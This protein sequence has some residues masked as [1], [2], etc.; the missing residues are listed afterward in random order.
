MN[1]LLYLLTSLLYILSFP[2]FNLS[3][4]AWV[5]L[6]PL[7]IAV[8]REKD[9]RNV[10]RGTL[11]SG[12]IIF[13]GGMYWLTNVTWVGYILLTFYMAWF[14]V[15][16]GVMRFYNKNLI[17][18]PLAWTAL[19]F[20]RSNFL[21]GIPWLLLGASQYNFL[22]LI[23]I[24]NI[25][26]VYGVSFIVALINIG[27]IRRKV[28]CVLILLLVVG[29][30]KI[31][32]NKQ[33]SG[34]K[35]KVGIVQPNIAQDIKWDPEYSYWMLDKLEALS[36]R[37]EKADLIIWPE[38]AVPLFIEKKGLLDRVSLLPQR[39]N[40]NLILGAQG[41]DTD[42]KKHYYNSAF[43]LS[44]EGKI[45]GEYRKIHLVPFGEYVPFKGV[46]PFL[47]SVTPIE[48]G[49]NAG[50]EYTVFQMPDIKC[51]PSTLICFEDIFPG[52][53]RRFVERGADILINITNDA[54][55]GKTS[56]VYQ[57]A[58]LSVFRAVENKVPLIRV[59]NTGLSCFVDHTGKIYPIQP[60]SERSDVREILVTKGNTFYTRYGDKFSRM[61]LFVL[62]LLIIKEGLWQ[63]KK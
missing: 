57:H 17:I 54:W 58:Y 2:N 36:E 19:E 25:T 60:F 13:L 9:I 62:L 11:L 23:Q 42:E 1:L 38:T 20:I 51:Q 26:G 21:G 7:L 47:K 32:L 37:V 61:C 15:L 59:T 12:W 49:F 4:L 22:S 16:F 46:F 34:E 52:L 33:I 45:K 29:Y 55:F 3:W 8:D 31:E 43:F 10:I 35:I 28:S 18:V 63:S 50:S 48:E 30:G 24:S 14:I 27:I 44:K 39:L 40:C 56:A 6:V 5:S 41:V 53:A